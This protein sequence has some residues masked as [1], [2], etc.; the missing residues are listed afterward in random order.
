MLL[1]LLLRYM[2]PELLR[3]ADDDKNHHQNKTYTNKV[4]IWGLGVVL[5]EG[6]RVKMTKKTLSA[7]VS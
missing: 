1:W 3:L 7:K 4:D 5:F 2:A 6:L